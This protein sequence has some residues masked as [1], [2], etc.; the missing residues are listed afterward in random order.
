MYLA[1]L[2]LCNF[3]NFEHSNFEFS[4]SFN[5]FIGKNA[6]GKTN[7]IEAIFLLSHGNSFR[8]S[9]FRDMIYRGNP[10]AEIS[11]KAT[12]KL[13]DDS[14]RV[15]IDDSRKGFFLNE[16]KT[17]PGGFKGVSTVLFAPEA[18]LLLRDSPSARRRYIDEFI[19][20]AVPSYRTVVRRYE[21]ILSQR[22][23]LL[24][25]RIEGRQ[26]DTVLFQSFTYQLV[27]LGAYLIMNRHKWCCEI[28]HILPQKYSG[29]APNDGAA[30][31][32]YC[33]HCG[34]D[35]VDKGIEG[36]KAALEDELVRREGDEFIRGITLIGPHRDDIEARIE[37]ERLCHFG[38]QGQHRTFVLALK[39]TEMDLLS[40]A[41]DEVPIML[42]DDVASE[43]DIDRAQGF[44]A[45]LEE[46]KGQVF[47]T[48]VDADDVR[49]SGAGRARR[50]AIEAGGVQFT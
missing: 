41:H 45:H 15:L 40:K 1:T 49:L 14:L 38:S 21:R 42:L 34:G 16:K 28:N 35:A 13:G 19:A 18:V 23:R 39:M 37:E 33:P 7:V 4:P 10:V 17:T 47:V 25:N 24:Q 3:R 8:T 50:F 12:C 11:S 2:S 43:L 22:N 48:A 32:V 31:F 46:A 26:F 9:E 20:Q 27:S 30:T 6:Q 5:I 29:M 44:F 36:L